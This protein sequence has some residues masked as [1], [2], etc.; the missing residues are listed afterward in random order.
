MV[1]SS[2]PLQGAPYIFTHGSKNGCGAYVINNQEPILC[3]YQPSS[4]QIIELKIV[5]L[6]L[7][8][9]LIQHIC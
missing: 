2:V 3:Q 9:Y 5:P 6:P 4:P 1:T 7:I 8:C